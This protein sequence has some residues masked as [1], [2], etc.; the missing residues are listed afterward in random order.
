M[1]FEENACITENL[2]KWEGQL[3]L[4]FEIVYL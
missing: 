4:T 2:I 1:D 3:E